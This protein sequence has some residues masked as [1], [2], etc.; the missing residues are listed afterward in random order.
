MRLESQGTSNFKKMM[1][2]SL[3]DP[4]LLRGINTGSLMFHAIRT[5]KILHW[6]REKFATIVTANLTNLR[7]KFSL[8][9][10]TEKCQ[11]FECFRFV[12]H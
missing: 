10:F 4:I 8:D 5:K 6:V 2:F 1:V 12:L 9:H 3:Y 7:E 11:I